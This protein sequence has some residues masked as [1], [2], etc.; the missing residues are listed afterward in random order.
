MGLEWLPTNVRV[1]P[2]FSFNAE[3]LVFHS[4]W[5]PSKRTH[6]HVCVRMRETCTTTLEHAC[7]YVC[8][9]TH[10]LGFLGLNF[11]K[12]DFFSS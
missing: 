8:M 5:N 12:I 10:A 11:L 9:C 2:N 4:F 7:A 3:K 6:A 1:I